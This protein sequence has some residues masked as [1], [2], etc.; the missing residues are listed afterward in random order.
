MRR[1][2][3]CIVA[4]TTLLVWLTSFREVNQESHSTYTDPFNFTADTAFVDLTPYLINGSNY[5]IT[6]TIDLQG[7]TWYLPPNSTFEIKGG[8]ITNGIL[9]GITTRLK[10]VGTIFGNVHIKGQW[11]VSDITTNM[12]A[13]LTYENSL[14]DVF[15]LSNPK[16]KNRITIGNGIYNLAALEPSDHCLTVV[17]NSIIILDGEV[18]LAPNDYTGYSIFFLKGSNI[19]MSGTGL[20]EGDK[21][22]H[23]GT[24]GEWGMGIFI[25]G[26]QNI[27]IKDLSIKDCWGDCIYVTRKANNVLIEGC[28]LDNG[29]RQG[30]SIIS[31]DSVRVK[32]CSITNVG[33]TEPEYAI[34]VE[35][36]KGDSVK[37]VLIKNVRVRDCKG[38][39]A[40]YRNAK[41]TYINTVVIQNCSI[42][43]TEK[44]PMAFINTNNVYIKDN[45]ID[46]YASDKVFCFNKVYYVNSVRNKVS[47]RR[48]KNNRNGMR[49]FDIKEVK[50]FVLE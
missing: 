2:C 7:K 11:I 44:S 45:V 18:R 25:S 37:H 15:A 8:F 3:I 29:R 49:Y 50:R 47:G 48:V 5:V 13:D 46:K 10:Y 38:G 34:D 19:I 16:V 41:D 30:I 32:N 43:N 14:K 35:P 42:Y 27:S 26:G 22:T 31:A 24:N 21:F 33:G 20:I 23:T 9:Y 12:F 4:V 1:W 40:S 36:N 6:D 17:S 28:R 39:F